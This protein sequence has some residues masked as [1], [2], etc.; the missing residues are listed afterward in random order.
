VWDHWTLGVNLRYGEPNWNSPRCRV[1]PSPARNF[2]KRSTVSPLTCCIVA[3]LVVLFFKFI[4]VSNM[5]RVLELWKKLRRALH[6]WTSKNIVLWSLLHPRGLTLDNLDDIFQCAWIILSE[7]LPAVLKPVS[8]N[9]V[10][11]MSVPTA[12]EPE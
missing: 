5:N 12:K 10:V 1:L 2:F 9:D 3:R 6:I 11:Q 4:N 7:L 8:H